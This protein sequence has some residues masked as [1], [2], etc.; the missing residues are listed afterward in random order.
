MYKLGANTVV[1]LAA[2]AR[3][4]GYTNV[5]EDPADISNEA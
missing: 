2:I 5:A 1:E 4:C 3:A